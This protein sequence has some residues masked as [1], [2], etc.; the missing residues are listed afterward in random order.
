[1]M[2]YNLLEYYIS[3]HKITLTLFL[4]CVNVNH[5]EDNP[6]YITCECIYSN[7]D[8]EYCLD[9]ELCVRDERCPE[10]DGQ[11]TGIQ[12]YDLNLSKYNNVFHVILI[13]NALV[14]WNYR[15]P[16]LLR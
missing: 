7:T 4:D 14:F 1:M 13:L 16:F 8:L 3:C 5:I 10:S 9:N 11:P 2:D 12:V 6:G 15:V